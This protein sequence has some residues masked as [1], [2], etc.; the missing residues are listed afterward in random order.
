[1]GSKLEDVK[2]KMWLFFEDPM[3]NKWSM[4]YWLLVV[5]VTLLSV[6]LIALETVQSLNLRD[7]MAFDETEYAIYGVFTLD[8]VLRAICAPSFVAFCANFYNIIDLL[9]LLPFYLYQAFEFTDESFMNLIYLLRPSIRLLVL[10]RNFFGFRLLVKSLTL[11]ADSLSIPMFLLFLMVVT[12]GV[13]V[14]FFEHTSNPLIDS[15]PQGMYLAVATI[16]TV[17]FGDVYPITVAGKITVSIMIITGVLYMA[18]PLAIV[19]SN[20]LQVWEDRDRIL[21]VSRVRDRLIQ[22]GLSPDDLVQAFRN[23]DSDFDGDI[24]I[25]EFSTFIKSLGLGLSHERIVD[26]FMA[27][28]TDE[29]GQLLLAEFA[30]ALFPNH[31]W[32]EDELRAIEVELFSR[33]PAAGTDGV[34]LPTGFVDNLE[35]IRREVIEEEESEMSE[36]VLTEEVLPE[37]HTLMSEL[38]RRIDD[39]NSRLNAVEHS[40]NR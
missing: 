5:G 8:F 38:L 19:G 37:N 9:S 26:L 36:I 20:F 32:T 21:L 1:M 18:M 7:R 31:I 10:S 12:G 15:I 30:R 27:F 11:S 35:G 6:V 40:T 33:A 34:T 29:N 14:F 2:K 3:S 4:I 28:D 13:F 24:G 25:D 39:L 17:G 22:F 23:F 16:S